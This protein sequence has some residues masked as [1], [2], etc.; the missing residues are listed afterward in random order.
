MAEILTIVFSVL[1]VI[2]LL[3]FIIGFLKPVLDNKRVTASQLWQSIKGFFAGLFAFIRTAFAFLFSISTLLLTGLIGF[4]IL[5][6]GIFILGVAFDNGSYEFLTTYDNAQ[7]GLLFDIFDLIDA[8]KGFLIAA[9]RA[10]IG[11]ISGYFGMFRTGVQILLTDILY[12]CIQ[13]DLVQ[14]TLDIIKFLVDFTR[15]IVYYGEDLLKFFNGGP[16]PELDI[17]TPASDLLGLLKYIRDLFVCGCDAIGFI[18]DF[19]W[20]AL[21]QNSIARLLHNGVQIIIAADFEVLRVAVSNVYLIQDLVAGNYSEMLE[22]IFDPHRPI[23]IYR[24]TNYTSAAIEDA[25]NIVD[26]VIY[27]YLEVFWGWIP[28]DYMIPLNWGIIDPG[29]DIGYWENITIHSVTPRVGRIIVA[30][31]KISI[32]ITLWGA[33][34]ALHWDLAFLGLWNERINDHLDLVFD[35]AYTLTDD[36]ADVFDIEGIEVSE[37]FGCV[38]RTVLH[39]IV[40]LPN[41]FIRIFYNT[42]SYLIRL[43]LCQIFED[44]CPVGSAGINIF[45]YRIEG[46]IDMVDEDIN[47]SAPCIN[48]TGVILTIPEVAGFINRGALIHAKFLRWMLKIGRNFDAPI[49]DYVSTSEFQDDANSYLI[50]AAR[51]G[52]D[53][54]NFMNTIAYYEDCPIIDPNTITDIHDPYPPVGIDFVCGAGAILQ[55]VI[56]VFLTVITTISEFAIFL[57]QDV[58]QEITTIGD[59]PDLRDLWVRAFAQ[60]GGIF[61]LEFLLIQHVRRIGEGVAAMFASVIRFQNTIIMDNIAQTEIEPFISIEALN[62]TAFPTNIC[63][64]SDVFWWD[65]WFNLF[66]DAFRIFTII[67]EG[68]RIV[69]TVTTRVIQYDCADACCGELLIGNSTVEVNNCACFIADSIYDNTIGQLLTTISD[70]FRLVECYFFIPSIVKDE[71]DIEAVQLFLPIPIGSDAVKDALIDTMNIVSGLFGEVADA[72]DEINGILIDIICDIL[73]LLVSIIR[74]LVILFTQPIEDFVHELIDTAQEFF[75][76]LGEA[77]VPQDLKDIINAILNTLNCLRSKIIQV[78]GCAYSF[79]PCIYIDWPIYATICAPTSVVIPD[80]GCIY[81]VLADWSC[82]TTTGLVARN[83]RMVPRYENVPIECTEDYELWIT[84][85]ENSKIYKLLKHQYEW[86]MFVY[87]VTGVFGVEDRM[88]FYWWTDIWS[89]LSQF[90]RDVWITVVHTLTY[91]L[92]NNP[93]LTVPDYII[94]VRNITNSS[95]EYPLPKMTIHVMNIIHILR[96]ARPMVIDDALKLIRT[97]GIMSFKLGQGTGLYWNQTSGFTSWSLGGTKYSTVSFFKY[98]AK[99]YFNVSL[100]K[101]KTNLSQEVSQITNLYSLKMATTFFNDPYHHA[102]Y[103]ARAVPAIKNALV[104][105]WIWETEYHGN[106][107]LEPG[108][109][110]GLHRD[111]EMWTVLRNLELKSTCAEAANY[112]KR[113]RDRLFPYMTKGPDY[114]YSKDIPALKNAFV[115]TDCEEAR[116]CFDIFGRIV[117]NCFKD[118]TST[119]PLELISC[120]CN[121]PSTAG[122]CCLPNSTC[123]IAISENDCLTLMSGVGFTRGGTCNVSYTGHHLCNFVKGDLGACCLGDLRTKTAGCEMLTHPDCIAANGIWQ[124]NLTCDVHIGLA[125]TC[126]S[127]T[128]AFLPINQFTEEVFCPDQLLIAEFTNTTVSP[129]PCADRKC[130]NMLGEEIGTCANSDDIPLYE[131]FIPSWLRA[132]TCGCIKDSGLQFACCNMPNNT[133]LD[134]TNITDVELCIAQQGNWIEGISCAECPYLDLDPTEYGACCYKEYPSENPK[135]DLLSVEQDCLNIGG[136]WHQ[137][138]R[139]NSPYLSGECDHCTARGCRDCKWLRDPVNY[140]MKIVTVYANLFIDIVA[141]KEEPEQ[142]HEINRRMYSRPGAIKYDVRRYRSPTLKKSVVFDNPVV[143]TVLVIAEFIINGFIDLF[144]LIIRLFSFIFGFEFEDPGDF[145]IRQFIEDIVAFASWD[146]PFDPTTFRYWFRKFFGLIPYN[147]FAECRIVEDNLQNLNGGVG[148]A[149]GAIYTSLL[150]GIFFYISSF[151]FKGALFGTLLRV[152][153]TWQIIVKIW[154]SFAFDMPTA[155]Y[156]DTIVF[157]PMVYIY[158]LPLTGGGGITGNLLGSGGGSLGLGGNLGG[159]V[160]AGGGGTA[161]GNTGFT[162]PI[163]IPY[164][165]PVYGLFG[166]FQWPIILFD[167]L[168]EFYDTYI[169][170]RFLFCP[171]DPC[172]DPHLPPYSFE[173]VRGIFYLMKRYYNPVYCTLLESDSIYLS[174]IRTIPWLEERYTFPGESCDDISQITG[175]NWRNGMIFNVLSTIFWSIV[176]LI[177]AVIIVFLLILAIVAI[178]VLMYVL[179]VI[180]NSFILYPLYMCVGGLK[181]IRISSIRKFISRSRTKVKDQ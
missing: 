94:T 49:W 30:L 124:Q 123:V 81:T 137:G 166:T 86:C 57:S 160:G 18:W 63:P 111:V 77:L 34:T 40:H 156:Q 102:K 50:E 48:R 178:G 68:I 129:A 121:Y 5:L 168:F 43:L 26:G 118:L 47:A 84:E 90:V 131:Q 147:I 157:I 98:A 32:L 25:S 139:C 42:Y 23:D 83:A 35:T 96:N 130:W 127:C 79:T 85:P 70:I 55:T 44:I 24:I 134:T 146:N 164:L 80:F 87:N 109:Y 56:R 38:V 89:I 158:D 141:V 112:Y 119:D 116:R 180:V 150:I 181:G 8:L 1:L 174:W 100:G 2:F 69:L 13:F 140:I 117:G 179:G 54:G 162:L 138:Q 74:L 103:D 93:D 101:I 64:Q 45:N 21:S 72:V 143:N 4:I 88:A 6:I 11:A 76:L 10:I 108:P 106:P 154:A 132:N 153:F 113:E 7:K 128:S 3:E 71:F 169:N 46:I 31:P 91:L 78:F 28:L 16:V 58:F 22:Y 110:R 175:Q 52:I 15:S 177:G 105:R 51:L 170:T 73:S 126:G 75:I 53:V 99:K 29:R 37:G 145:D 20:R 60:P 133:C 176:F 135:C 59:F 172:D 120:A 161:D 33:N 167:K 151:F 92:E 14:L 36:I 19:I 165:L 171:E 65:R 67:P 82:F 155:C 107:A 122:A 149:W 136:I 12:N 173:D 95:M 27:S 152:I 125:Q 61:D 142:V 159:N 97:G 114:D 115:E 66:R 144:V 17:Y 9:G 62:L 104:N 148:F 39:Q 163:P 41:S